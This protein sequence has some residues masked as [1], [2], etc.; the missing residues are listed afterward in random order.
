MTYMC[1]FVFYESTLV[2][3]P[4]EWISGAVCMYI[5]DQ[6]V[7]LY[8]E[9]DPQVTGIL[10]S[11]EIILIPFVNPDGYV[12]TW[13]HDRLWR[14]NRRTVG[15]QSGRPNPCVGVD[16]NRNFPEGWR[17]G[18][19][20]SNNPVE[21]SEDYGGPNPMSEPETRNIINYWK[22]NGPIVGA[23]DWHSYGQLILHPWAFTKDDPKHDE[24]IKQ[25]G[26]NMA[27]A[28][29]EVHGTDYTSEK[30]ID[31]YQCFGIAS[32]WFY[33]DDASS[34]N[35]GYRAVGYVIEL[36]DTGTKGFLLPPDQILPTGQ[37][38]FPAV[39]LFAKTLLEHPISYAA[40]DA[41]V[42]SEGFSPMRFRGRYGSQY[43]S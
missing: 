38:I 15:S 16:I 41:M 34:T 24:Q 5:V 3:F 21:C 19:K 9:S 20:K 29:K 8:D 10:D 31:L 7:T 39:L 17:E 25:L 32:D 23:I 4:G 37:E 33:G 28:I 27:K 35:G 43:N 42:Q 1:C 13:A 36:R 26:S 18:G 30:S 12:Y 40:H 11:A 14:K 6:M 22:A 2:C